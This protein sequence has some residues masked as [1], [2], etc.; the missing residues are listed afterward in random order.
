MQLDVDLFDL[1]ARVCSTAS[2]S[3]MKCAASLGKKNLS[4]SSQKKLMHHRQLF[5]DTWH[6]C[7]IREYAQTAA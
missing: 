3:D 7:A 2:F 4:V 1:H 6:Q 5:H